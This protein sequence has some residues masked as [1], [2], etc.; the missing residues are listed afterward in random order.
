MRR[1]FLF[2]SMLAASLTRAQPADTKIQEA[3]F[4]I[5]LPGRWTATSREEDD[6]LFV[7][8]SDSNEQVTVSIFLAQPRL[9]ESEL[10]EKFASFIQGRRSAE[11]TQD[12]DV[13]LLE[14]RVAR[15][16]HGITG[17]YQGRSKSGRRLAN[18]AIVNSA[19]IANFYYEASVPA[20]VFA[21]RAR[22]ILGEVTFVE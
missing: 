16:G 7:Y 3:Y 10:E 8:S 21:E 1:L 11:G 17:F 18:F 19:G 2:L 4:S 9:R 15:P 14:T 6:G 13:E 12:P 20:D 22:S 5:S